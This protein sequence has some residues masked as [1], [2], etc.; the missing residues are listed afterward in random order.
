MNWI[1]LEDVFTKLFDKLH[2]SM[3]AFYDTERKD[4]FDETQFYN[5]IELK[6]ETLDHPTE[7]VKLYHNEQSRGY[8]ANLFWNIVKE[9]FDEFRQELH[10]QGLECL[11]LDGGISTSMTH[12]SKKLK[13]LIPDVFSVTMMFT[14]RGEAISDQFFEMDVNFRQS[15]RKLSEMLREP[16]LAGFQ[17]SKER[18]HVRLSGDPDWRSKKDVLVYRYYIAMALNELETLVTKIA[19]TDAS[20]FIMRHVMLVERL[21]EIE[22]DYLRIR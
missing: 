13:L 4:P 8:S 7:C 15:D 1:T 17:N 20:L 10:R 12:H 2:L 3:N 9:A 18:M 6:D 14:R 21:F 19:P 11:L 22:R 16:F 5:R